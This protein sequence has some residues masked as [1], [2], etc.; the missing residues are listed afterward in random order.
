MMSERR[1]GGGMAVG[2]DECCGRGLRTQV[3][4]AAGG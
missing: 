2:E 1:A 4:L 3:Q